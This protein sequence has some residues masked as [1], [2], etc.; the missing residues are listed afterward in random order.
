M[1]QVKIAKL[2]LKMEETHRIKKN[3]TMFIMAIIT[4]SLF[5]W[6]KNLQ[7]KMYSISA[8]DKKMEK[9]TF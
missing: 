5:E 1:N 8:K 7:T 3:E 6:Q 9:L 4:S 2:L